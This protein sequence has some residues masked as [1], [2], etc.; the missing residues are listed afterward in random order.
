MNK[1]FTLI[2]LLVV[3]AILGIFAVLG[4][5]SYMNSLRSGKD[6]RRKTDLQTI[7]KALEEY[8]LDNQA[9]PVGSIPDPFC[10]PGGCAT[11]Q[12]LPVLPKD[13]GGTP[14]AYESSDGAYYRLYSCIENPNDAGAGVNQSGYGIS[15]GFGICDPCRYGVSS[16]NV[17]L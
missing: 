5:S 12:Y 7:Q 17:S 8:Y 15:C 11:A 1:S 9:Y 6:A 2:E 13:Q 10:H 16:S 3:L 4:F 14:Y